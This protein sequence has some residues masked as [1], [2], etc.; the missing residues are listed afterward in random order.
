MLLAGSVRPIAEANARTAAVLRNELKPSALQGLS[1]IVDSSLSNLSLARLEIRN[2][3]AGHLTRLGQ[4][5]SAPIEKA[6]PRSALRARNR[7]FG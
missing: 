3:S 7:F 6:T 5:L 1:D 2:R 4:S